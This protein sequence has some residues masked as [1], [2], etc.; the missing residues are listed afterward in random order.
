MYV[1]TQ[2]QELGFIYSLI[3]CLLWVTC[4]ATG[5]YICAGF[6]SHALRSFLVL[7][8]GPLSQPYTETLE[9]QP[10]DPIYFPVFPVCESRTC[11]GMQQ[12]SR[13]SCSQ[14]KP[15]QLVGTCFPSHMG[16]V[17]VQVTPQ[18]MHTIKQVCSC[19]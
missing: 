8:V 12:T 17:P 6:Y 4:L 11:C 16:T 1:N 10:Q 5:W 19:S 14:K 7:R 2:V 15:N 18:L 3:P 9:R 13:H